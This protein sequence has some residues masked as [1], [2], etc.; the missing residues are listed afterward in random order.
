MEYCFHLVIL[1]SYGNIA[2]I[3]NKNFINGGIYIIYIF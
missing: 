3:Y 2:F 1:F